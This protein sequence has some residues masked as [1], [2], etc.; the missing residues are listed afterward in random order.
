MPVG[1][2]VDERSGNVRVGLH[3]HDLGPEPGLE[4]RAREREVEAVDV[5]LEHV[6]VVDRDAG[7]A[8]PRR[9]GD[10]VGVLLHDRDAVRAEGGEVVLEGVEDELVALEGGAAGAALEEREGGVVGVAVEGA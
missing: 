9:H 3:Q 10:R 5:D 4:D 6:E 7:G 1:R 8:E 2:L